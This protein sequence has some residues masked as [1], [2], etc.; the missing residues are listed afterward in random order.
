MKTL[1]R[2]LST[3]ANTSCNDNNYCVQ[4]FCVY[5]RI[6]RMVCVSLMHVLMLVGYIPWHEQQRGG[7]GRE[8]VGGREYYVHV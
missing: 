4:L 1:L 7:G 2:K 3:V 8:G 6:Y 5:Y